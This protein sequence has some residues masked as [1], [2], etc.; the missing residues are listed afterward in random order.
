MK[1]DAEVFRRFRA[2]APAERR[3]LIARLGLEESDAFDRAWAHWAHEGQRPPDGDEWRSWVLMAG[4]GFGKTLA[5]AKW[6]TEAVA[7][8]GRERG[9]KLS[10]AL[11]GAT[12]EE[13]RRVMVEGRSGLLEVASGWI[14][15]WSPALGRLRFR[16]GAEAVL[17]SGASP[18]RLR[19]PEHHF[20]WCDELAKWEKP[21]RAGT[22][23]NSAFA[24]GRGRG[25]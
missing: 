2:M 8:A 20:A 24:W 22:C 15:E 17:F 19:G 25:R 21:R 10:I 7:A 3:R 18:D 4:R 23:C 6:I 1:V 9:E 12:L 13:A 11:V 16:T 5:G 14:R